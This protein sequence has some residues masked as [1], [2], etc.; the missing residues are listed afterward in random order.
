M[1]YISADKSLTGETGHDLCH[2]TVQIRVLWALQLQFGVANLIQRFVLL[3]VSHCKWY[4]ATHVDTTSDIRVFDQVVGGQDTVVRLDDCFRHFW[5]RK[6]GESSEHS[7]WEFLSDFTK[8]QRS[9]T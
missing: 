7:V 6:D 4:V 8:Q 3:L 9:E 5:R 2:D 1:L